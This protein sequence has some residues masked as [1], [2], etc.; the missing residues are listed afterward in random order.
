M[1]STGIVRKLDE[2]GRIV[3]PKEVR[4]SL[5][6][7]EKDPIEI[8]VS[9]ETIILKKVEKNCILCSSV[10]ELIEYKNKLICH[11]CIEKLK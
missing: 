6:I 3:I 4:H 9:G 5:N 8:Y 1:K 10:N 11:R 7:S 2:L